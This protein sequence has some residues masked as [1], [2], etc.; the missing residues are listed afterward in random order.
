[1]SAIHHHDLRRR[2]PLGDLPV[3]HQP[4]DENQDLIFP[5]WLD[6]L[7]IM[8]V[9]YGYHGDVTLV[10]QA[11]LAASHP[12]TR[13]QIHEDP[14]SYHAASPGHSNNHDSTTTIPGYNPDTPPK[15]PESSNNNNNST[16]RPHHKGHHKRKRSDL[17]DLVST[18]IEE[19]A[20]SSLF[21]KPRT[22]SVKTLQEAT[23]EN[24][25]H[26]ASL[27]LQLLSLSS[28]Q[29]VNLVAELVDSRP[30]LKQEIQHK[31]PEPDLTGQ[32]QRLS[33]LTHNI[34][35][36]LPRSRIC[37]SRGAMCY[38][39][40][41]V[42]LAAFKKFCLHQ[43]RHLVRC[44][45]WKAVIEYSLMAWHYTTNLPI[46]DN[47]AHNK[48]KESCF[49][50]LTLICMRALKHGQLD[51]PTL[52]QFRSRMQAASSANK[53]MDLCIKRLDSRLQQ[54]ATL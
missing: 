23:V 14:P 1:M 30:G 33:Q 29:L 36:A 16:V 54:L 18:S 10:T 7:P 11:S 50:G 40:V 31:L 44:R 43:G 35:R 47:P 41:Y 34:Y 28:A 8:P 4:V 9:G 24:S 37:S 15:T 49:Q 46:W 48:C 3:S 53:V 38:R 19:T 21:K 2:P 22:V 39:R 12:I 32:S 17:N 45:S 27:E 6:V 25:G 5:P 20:S 42:H 26:H 51:K 52:T 13:I